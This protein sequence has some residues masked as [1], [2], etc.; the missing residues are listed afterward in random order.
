[1]RKTLLKIQVRIFGSVMQARWSDGLCG[2]CPGG[3]DKVRR[4]GAD[5]PITG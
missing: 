5:W 4:Q 2:A 1:L 3:P